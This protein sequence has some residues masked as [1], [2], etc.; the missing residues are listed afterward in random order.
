MLDKLSELH[1]FGDSHMLP[2]EQSSL[3][4]PSVMERKRQ[5]GI[6]RPN[7]FSISLRSVPMLVSIEK[8]G[9]YTVPLHGLVNDIELKLQ[10]AHHAQLRTALLRQVGDR[11]PLSFHI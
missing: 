8:V 2:N 1:L 11:A 9:F 5:S 3:N 4:F 6:F 10:A 7:F